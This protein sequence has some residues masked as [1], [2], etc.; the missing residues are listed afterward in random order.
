[1]I[2]FVKSPNSVRNSIMSSCAVKSSFKAG[3]TDLPL[4]IN[5]IDNV[6]DPDP[7]IRHPDPGSGSFYH[8]AKIVRQTLIPN[9]CDFFMPFYLWKIR[10]R[11][12]IHTKM[13]R[14]RNTAWYTLPYLFWQNIVFTLQIGDYFF[15]NLNLFLLPHKPIFCDW[16]IFSKG[17][18]LSPWM[19]DIVDYGIGLRTGLQA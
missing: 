16:P 15:L 19:R 9:V 6:A 7:L 10:S 5:H 1:M 18:I 13:S 4:E 2:L 3:F 8:Q 14:I 11:I 12:R 17:K